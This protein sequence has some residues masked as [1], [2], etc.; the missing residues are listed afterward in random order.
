MQ[1]W[2]GEIDSFEELGRMARRYHVQ[3][4]VI[5]A[6]PETRKARELQQALGEGVVWLAYYVSQRIGTKREAPIQWDHDNGVVNLDRTRSLDQTLARFYDASAGGPGATLPGDAREIPGYYEHLTAPVR[7][8]E[9]GPGGERVA[10]YVCQGADHLFHAENYAMVA[11]EAP[12][13]G[14]GFS[15]AY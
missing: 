15:F 12:A 9:D 8:L 11:G 13:A 7:V 6:L 4:L 1:V 14:R 2:A 5:D 10:R 3:R